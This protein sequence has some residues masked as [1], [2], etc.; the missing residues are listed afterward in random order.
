MSRKV[1]WWIISHPCNGARQ[2]GRKSWPSSRRCST[3]THGIVSRH[4]F[5]SLYV[6]TSQVLAWNYRRYVLASMPDQ[7][8]I[9]TELAYTTRKISASF[10]NFSAWHQ[11]SKVYS[12]LWNAGELN[13]RD[14]REE[15]TYLLCLQRSVVLTRQSKSLISYT[16]PSS[17]ILMIKARGSITGGS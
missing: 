9:M 5:R 11:R 15:G 4:S 13:P 1:Q 16:M 12:T 8:P 17:P 6:S 3:R 7:R 10:S 14:S 2:T